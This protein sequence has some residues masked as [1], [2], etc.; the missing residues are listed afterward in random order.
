M[1]KKCLARGGSFLHAAFRHLLKIL[2]CLC[3]G[4]GSTFFIGWLYTAKQ[5]F[6][7]AKTVDS[8]YNSSW[9]VP[10]AMLA[11][12]VQ[13][14]ALAKREKAQAG[15]NAISGLKALLFQGSLSHFIALPEYAKLI[16]THK[17]FSSSLL[18]VCDF[19]S[20]VKCQALK[21]C[22]K[23]GGECTCKR[24]QCAFP[25][26]AV[27]FGTK[28]CGHHVKKVS[29]DFVHTVSISKLTQVSNN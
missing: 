10:L 22:C 27:A 13:K 4:F 18:P 17:C 1:A 12:S 20:S 3:F 6:G 19:I 9:Q 24:A 5:S 28:L 8:S 16:A 23:K 2:S 25:S 15:L 11:N 14:A 26:T 29:N 7:I 21:N